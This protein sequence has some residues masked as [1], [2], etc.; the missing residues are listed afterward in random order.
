RHPPARRDAR[1]PAR[2]DRQLLPPSLGVAGRGDVFA[3]GQGGGA[4]RSRAGGN[5]VRED[6]GRGGGWRRREGESPSR[7]TDGHGRAA[8]S[9]GVHGTEVLEL[10]D[11]SV[12]ALS[13]DRMKR[14][15]SFARW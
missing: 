3:R 9:R 5:A 1:L 12:V 4:G 13:Q 8:P 15:A 11:R 10:D 14:L 6:T 2:G 7:R